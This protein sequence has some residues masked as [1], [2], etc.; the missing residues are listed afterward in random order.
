[1]E[2]NRQD[3]RMTGC[4]VVDI[5]RFLRLTRGAGIDKRWE[6]Q[7]PSCLTS[8]LGELDTLDVLVR[9]YALI[10]S[11]LRTRLAPGR[12]K[13]RESCELVVQGLI[14]SACMYKLSLQC[15]VDRRYPSPQN[16]KQDQS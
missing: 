11:C 10:W 7:V 14:V 8:H 15:N 16:S 4:D 6:R 9:G 12:E 1:M 5:T 13:C 2:M 3:R